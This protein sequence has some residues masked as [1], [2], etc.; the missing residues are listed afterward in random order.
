MNDFY[1]Y[2]YLRENGTPYYIGKG[3]HK[4]SK[5]KNY[6]KYHRA[7]YGKHS[8][9]VPPKNRVLI[10]KDNLTEDDAFKNEKYLIFVFGRKDVNNGILL[11]LT[12]GGEGFSGFKLSEPRKKDISKRMKT[13]IEKNGNPN[14]KKYL[15]VNITGESYIVDDGFDKFCKSKNIPY[16]AIRKKK[17]RGSK[18]PTTCGWYYYNITKKTSDEIELIKKDFIL[19]YKCDN[20][21][22]DVKIESRN[23]SVSKRS[24]LVLFNYIKSNIESESEKLIEYNGNKFLRISMSDFKEEC[25]ISEKT[26]NRAVKTL[27]K[28]N[29]IAIKKLNKHNFDQTNYYSINN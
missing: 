20:N 6:R 3:K 7:F 10:L 13:Y 27:E 17:Q 28:N 21:H 16:E 5:N 25:K 11:N 2:A 19:K 26:V 18:T 29:L 22:I 24:I 4:L 12:N 15:V 9:P 1:T 8:V 14:L 23:G